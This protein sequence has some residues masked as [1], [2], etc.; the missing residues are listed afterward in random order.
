MAT[1]TDA[2]AQRLRELREAEVEAIGFGVSLKAQNYYRQRVAALD[3][4]LS[5]IA[6][7]ADLRARLVAAD[8]YR[9]F[10]GRRAMALAFE[11]LE[12]KSSLAEAK[13]LLA[14]ASDELGRIEQSEVSQ[15]GKG[16][17]G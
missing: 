8:R 17:D 1:D 11:V 2:L 4:A 9:E 16:A 5:A 7:L 3:Y 14:R 6:E 13:A 12:L 10:F 15:N